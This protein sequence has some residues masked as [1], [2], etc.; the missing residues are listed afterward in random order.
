MKVAKYLRTNPRKVSENLHLKLR[1]V[2]TKR[3]RASQARSLLNRAIATGIVP[4]GIDIRWIDWEK[5]VGGKVR[6]GRI[7]P[8]TMRKALR[9]FY[10]ALTKGSSR[11]ARV[12]N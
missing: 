2:V 5:G 9:S 1:V 11:F 12:R 3:M 10:N 6:E 8:D 4:T 7:L